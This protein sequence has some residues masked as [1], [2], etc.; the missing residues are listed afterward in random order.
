MAKVP[1]QMNTFKRI[2]ENRI[3]IEGIMY[4]TSFSKM[5]EVKNSDG[6]KIQSVRLHGIYYY[7]Y[8]IVD[9][10]KLK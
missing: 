1:T 7:P 9:P 6:S 10:T 4:H 3:V 8:K 2:D 5:I